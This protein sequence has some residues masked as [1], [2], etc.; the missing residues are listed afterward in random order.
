MA[1]RRR[2]RFVPPI[3]PSVR[4][5][6]SYH[7]ALR[8]LILQPM[9]SQIAER[10]ALA[11]RTQKAYLEA[12]NNLQLPEGWE[13]R[14]EAEIQAYFQRVTQWHWRQAQ[15][16]FGRALGI[17]IPLIGDGVQYDTAMRAR[18]VENVDYVRQVPVQGRARLLQAI[19]KQLEAAP[20]DE[21]RLAR[22]LNRQF[23]YEDYNLRRLTRDQTSKAV[24]N[25]T[26][27]RQTGAG[28]THYRWS[29]SLD[30]AVRSS[31]RLLESKIFAWSDPP[32]VGHPGNDI[33]CR[34]AAVPI[35]PR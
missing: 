30:E 12:V 27:E 16:T 20:F 26:Q 24:G 7:R 25:L 15:R 28:V 22:A 9:I 5:E 34:C 10:V 8:S 2:R 11:G 1:Q 35:L 23:G 6:R 4:L 14:S 17:R 29:T 13:R 33:Q 18:I 21:E 19:E 32:A 3:H 31:H